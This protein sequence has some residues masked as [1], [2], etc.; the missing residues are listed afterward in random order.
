MG[1]EVGDEH[2]LAAGDECR[3][4]DRHVVEQAETHG[5][6]ARRVVPRR[7]DRTERG[8]RTAGVQLVDGGQADPAPRYAMSTE[9]GLTAV[10]GSSCDG[11]TA[12][13]VEAC[14]EILRVHPGHFCG[15]R[16]AGL[17]RVHVVGDQRVG[18]TAEHA[19]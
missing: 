5:T 6:V 1:V 19:P 4:S 9:S 15:R 2:A 14:Q 16:R 13:L 8:S 3:R 18:R 12:H 7:A 17:D 11:A 10:S